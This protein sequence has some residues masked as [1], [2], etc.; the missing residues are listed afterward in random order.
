MKTYQIFASF[1]VVFSVATATA[2]T[3]AQGVVLERMQGMSALGDAMKVVAPMVRGQAE[4]DEA[5]VA[6][7]GGVFSAH[8]GTGLVALFADPMSAA[9]PSE[10][11]PAIWDDPD[12]FTELALQLEVLGAELTASA[13]SP[14]DT[15]EVFARIGQTC[16]ACHQDYRVKRD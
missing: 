6:R 4:H 3:G 15:A 12:G 8:A 2:H 7:A 11:G 5:A 14:A 16:I 1:A 13:A 10:A 9:A